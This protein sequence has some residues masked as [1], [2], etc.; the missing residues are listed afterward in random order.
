MKENIAWIILIVVIAAVITLII[1]SCTA[2]ISNDA[3]CEYLGYDGAG[4]GRLEGELQVYCV[5]YTPLE[6]LK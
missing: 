4:W 1:G 6:Q 3:L 5:K 2:T